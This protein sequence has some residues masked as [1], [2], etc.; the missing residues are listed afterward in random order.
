MTEDVF[1]IADPETLKGDATKQLEEIAEDFTNNRIDSMG[2]YMSAR[3][4]WENIN[5]N[6][7][8]RGK[9]N[10]ALRQQRLAIHQI[11]AIDMSKGDPIRKRYDPNE[12]LKNIPPELMNKKDIYLQDKVRSLRNL[13]KNIT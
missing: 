1:A 11:A 3:N 8:L 6:P 7:V 13:I 2:F 4:I 9:I 10:D 5:R 12:W